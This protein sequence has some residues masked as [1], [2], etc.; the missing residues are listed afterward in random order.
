M[1]N[2]EGF[3]APAHGLSALE[4]GDCACETVLLII[5]G[6]GCELVY[7]V[8]NVCQTWLKCALWG[9][10]PSYSLWS[11]GRGGASVI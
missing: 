8:I 10:I 7:T 4:I 6:C 5:A 2:N 11:C 3:D 9:I 1:I